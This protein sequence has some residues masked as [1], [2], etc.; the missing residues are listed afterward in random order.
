MEWLTSSLYSRSV[1]TEPIKTSSSSTTPF[2]CAAG[3]AAL[4]LMGHFYLNACRINVFEPPSPPSP[5]PSV[6]GNMRPSLRPSASG[7]WSASRWPTRDTSTSLVAMA[8]AASA[9]A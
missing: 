9:A 2:T 3:A 6:N 4:H 7:S 1:N 5:P 8:M